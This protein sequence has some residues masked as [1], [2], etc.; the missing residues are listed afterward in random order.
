[1]SM[2]PPEMTS[3]TAQPPRKAGMSGGAKLLIVLGV[4]VGIAVLL[5]CGSAIWFGVYVAG[6]MSQDPQVVQQ[7]TEEIAQIEI[8]DGLEPAGSFDFKIPFYG[9]MMLLA[10]HVD[11][12][13]ESVLVLFSMP[14][15][16]GT[17]N[18]DGCVRRL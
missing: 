2:S 8:P 17:A 13:T 9:R 10:V 18:Q 11:K 16:S 3:E 7:K 6:G 14:A 12:E 15:A 1:M 4:L 5:C